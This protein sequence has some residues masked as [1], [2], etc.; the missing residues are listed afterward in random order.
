[1]LAALANRGEH[2]AN[3]VLTSTDV[4]ATADMFDRKGGQGAG[5]C[6]M[7]SAAGGQYLVADAGGSDRLLNGL[8]PV[9]HRQAAELDSGMGLDGRQ[10]LEEPGLPGVC[11]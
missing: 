10:K 1:M 5:E 3:S 2:I 7:Q 9:N 8:L 11:S 4:S 6:R